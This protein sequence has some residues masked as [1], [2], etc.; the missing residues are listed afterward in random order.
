MR[1]KPQ[2]RSLAPAVGVRSAWSGGRSA[3]HQAHD[4]LATY[5]DTP[6]FVP[7][8]CAR[9]HEPTRPP[10]HPGLA[11]NAIAQERLFEAD[12]ELDG[13]RAPGWIGESGGATDGQVT[14]C[15]KHS[16][17]DDPVIPDAAAHRQRWIVHGDEDA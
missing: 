10:I 14:Q 11:A 13:R 7:Q 8:L 9:E 17:V 5:T 2:R 4:A 16:A 6:H 1:R 15:R 12:R 3:S